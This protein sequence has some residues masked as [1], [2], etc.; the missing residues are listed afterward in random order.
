MRYHWGLGIGHTYSRS[1]D[2][3]SQQTPPIVYETDNAEDSTMSATALLDQGVE[4]GEDSELGHD[5]DDV[6]F[7]DGNSDFSADDYQSPED[8]EECLELHDTYY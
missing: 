4:G 7:D 3:R 1:Q 8:Y 2:L 6:D 5:G